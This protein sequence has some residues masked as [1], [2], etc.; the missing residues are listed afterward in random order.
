MQIINIYPKNRRASH[1][2][3]QRLVYIYIYNLIPI[4]FTIYNYILNVYFFLN[5]FLKRIIFKSY[6]SIKDEISCNLHVLNT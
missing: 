6:N 2:H 3:A 1:T 4:K 5:I